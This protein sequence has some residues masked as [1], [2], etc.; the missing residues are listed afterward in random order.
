[1]I[2]KLT[3][4]RDKLNR[5]VTGVTLT[6]EDKPG[7]IPFGERRLCREIAEAFAGWKDG[8]AGFDSLT[9]YRNKSAVLKKEL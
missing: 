7:L 3:K 8:K 1:M 4:K 9:L 6:V 2:V 5:V